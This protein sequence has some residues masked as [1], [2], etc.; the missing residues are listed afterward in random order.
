MVRHKANFAVQRNLKNRKYK[1]KKL[2]KTAKIIKGDIT[3]Q[4]IDV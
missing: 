3:Q 4:H 2:Q 1:C